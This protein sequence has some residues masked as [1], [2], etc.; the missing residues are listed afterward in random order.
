MAR[1]PR[2]P[3]ILFIT[4]D[5][6]RGAATGYAGHPL[7]RTPNLD[8]LA[9]E[10]VAFLSHYANAA[11]CSPARA[12]LYTGL[13]QMNNRVCR[14]GSPLDDRFDNIARAARRAGYD[15]TLFGY[16]DQSPDP[17]TLPPGD[18]ALTSYEGVLPGLTVRLKL[19]E[20]ERPWL[21]WL[22]RQGLEFA[23]RQA[24][25]R[26]V[27]AAAEPVSPAPPAYSR[28]QTQTAFVAD[29]FIRWL[30]EQD[31]DRPWFAHL[32]FLR[33]HPPFIVPAPYNTMFDPV[34][35]DGFR[36]AATAEQEMAL[37]PLL[38]YGI[39]QTKKKSFVFGARGLV[40]DFPDA[41]FRQ[42]KAIYYGMIAEV[43]AQLGRIIE[44]LHAA[45]G[46]DRTL[47]IFTSDHAEMLGDHWQLGKGGFFD[48]SQH[49]PL[50]IRDPRQPT[51][52]GGRVTQFTEAVD[53]FPTL[54]G[55]CGIAPL[56]H[57]D[58][59]SL[60]PFLAGD[61]PAGWRD[62]VHWEFDFRDIA[63]QGAERWFG[64]PSTRLSMAVR[65]ELRYKYVHFA[66]LPPL[67]FDLEADPHNLTDL[68]GDARHLEVR[69]AM[70]EK[71]LGW[72]AEHLDQ[73]LALTELTTA[74]VVS[75]R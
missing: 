22:S 37:H 44:A 25:H 3:N 62:A 41:D 26:P 68:A 67:L 63:E 17:R 12:C 10:G 21:S 59:A 57:P 74:G 43:D 71:L 29:E 27:G 42:I 14:N 69:L 35:V 11:P 47:V 48:E 30:G 18:P 5:Q 23:D 39:G 13:Y 28:D 34:A 38:R 20:D 73:T 61:E 19:L 8:R 9:A 60:Q 4:A 49:V 54:L 66:G 7:V 50:V 55:L 52:H 75:A 40:R 16:T 65:R 64:L 1:D 45:G 36:R 33:P 15:P 24:A 46:W 53:I 72:R 70:A 2:R 32:S 31:A 56:H 51:G 6:W 58:G